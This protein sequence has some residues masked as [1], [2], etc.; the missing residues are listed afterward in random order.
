MAQDKFTITATLAQAGVV[1][2]VLLSYVKADGKSAKDSALINGKF[3]INGTTAFGNRCYLEFKPVARDT[4]KKR[5]YNR[6]LKNAEHGRII[7]I[8]ISFTTL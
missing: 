7:K 2:M 1:V 3:Q 5:R 4:S 6:L 8:G